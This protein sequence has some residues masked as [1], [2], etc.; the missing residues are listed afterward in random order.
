ME[1]RTL[2]KTGLTVSRLGMGLAEIG[3]QLTFSEVYEA[4]QVLNTA[5]DAG[6]N[7]L[8]TSACYGISEELIGRTVAHRRDEYVLATKCGHVAGEYDGDPWTKETIKHSI[9]RSLTRMKTEYVDLVQLHSCNVE[10][11][12]RG[13]VIE[14][15]LEARE[16]GKTR[17]VGYSGDNEAARWAV[18][19]GIFDTLQTS[20]NL[21]DQRARK[22]LFPEAK[23]REMGIIAKRPL[24]NAA[25]GARRSPSDYVRPYYERAQAMQTQGPLPDAPEH[26]ILLALGFV[27]AHDEVDTAI[28]GTRNP[29]HLASNVAWVEEA[30]PISEKT[31]AELH[32]R[33]ADR[34][35]HW[36]QKT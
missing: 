12:E 3:T 18:E 13:A 34:G 20:F 33:F 32:R 21:V 15:L 8:D 22:T 5:L 30:L 35:E 4:S 1:M 14:A 26:R 27:L 6:V 25:W 10:I 2:G 19:S 16:E 31:I 9:E 7:F 17:F 28:V 36:E 11:L 29:R 24:A 23:A